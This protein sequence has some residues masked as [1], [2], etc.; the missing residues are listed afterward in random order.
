M[1]A[2]ARSAA[3]TQY[4]TAWVF[5]IAVGVA[6]LVYILLSRHDQAALLRWASTNVHN[7][8]HDPV[9]CLIASAFFPSEFL[10]AWP[11][12]IALAMFGAC[13]VLGNWRTAVVCAAAHVIGTLVSEGIVAYRISHGDLPASDKF[14]TDVGPSYVVV[15][16]I[17]VAILF[18]G[19]LGRPAAVLDL[20]LLVFVGDIFSGLGQLNVS[21]VGHL[22]ALLVGGLLGG[23]LLWRMRLRPHGA[24]TYS[25]RVPPG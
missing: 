24:S 20:A 15:A 11:A 22:T 4:L 9:G 21:A 25:A 1:R 5:L 10:W 13:K 17:A 6:E 2:S 3:F 19:W 16:A 8:G 14:I 7:L 23:L 18:G 12:V